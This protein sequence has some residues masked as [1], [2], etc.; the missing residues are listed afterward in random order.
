MDDAQR[1]QQVTFNDIFS[2]RRPRDARAGLSSGLKSLGKG[3]VGG[4]VGLFAAP[5]VG[6]AQDGV[7]GFAKGVATGVAGAVILPVTGISV[8]AV[9]VCRGLINQPEAAAAARQGKVWDPDAR[10]WLEAPPTHVAVY[11]A[12]AA[13]RRGFALGPPPGA[14]MLHG[15]DP[16]QPHDYYSLLQVPRDAPPSLIKRQ[17][18]LLARAVHPDK[19]CGDPEAKAKFQ[20]LS[21]AYQVLSDPSLRQRYDAG[22]A[23][24]LD[25]ADLVGDAAAFFSALFGSEMFEHLVGELAIA[26]V[27]G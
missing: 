20:A 5:V 4:A 23:A 25:Q 17:Y 7:A 27:A 9:Q 26:T 10:R 12:A 2:L 18:Y 3:I 13:R 14:R 21:E 11:D 22:G 6:A 19:A 24:G 1:Q 16:R 8:G 15:N